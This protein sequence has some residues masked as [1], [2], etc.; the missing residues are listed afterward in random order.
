MI[1]Y[2]IVIAVDKKHLEQLKLVWRTWAR[3]K[4]SLLRQPMTV[5]YDD[6][7]SQD[8]IADVLK[9]YVNVKFYRWPWHG[10]DYGGDGL[11]KW[12]D[13]QRYKMLSGFVHVPAIPGA[14][15]TEYWLKVDVD[16][17]AT[18]QDDWIDEK[19]F[20]DSPAIV[21]QPWGYT[22]PADQMMQL[23]AWTGA[24]LHRMPDWIWQRPP[25][26]IIPKEGWKRVRHKRIISWC[27]FF[28]TEFTRVCSKLADECYGA[29][30]LPV[31]SQDGYLWYMAKRG[32]FP[33]I[34]ANMKSR[35]W[36]HRSSMKGIREAVK[37][38][39]KE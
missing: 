11:S 5:I 25:L 12:T 37:E 4:P 38:A 34:R 27:G 20:D 30:K 21:S 9:K 17:I 32:G 16:T 36:K 13:P 19:W 31:P 26:D 39:L 22:K 33:I 35:G 29:G 3:H 7:V 18:G 1:S 6:S 14:V 2:T 23:D 10:V 15:D 28:N 24:H 8:E